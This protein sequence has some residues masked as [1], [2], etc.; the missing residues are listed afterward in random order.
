MSTLRLFCYMTIG[1][2]LLALSPMLV[3]WAG[4][5]LVDGILW[6]HRVGILKAKP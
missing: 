1:Y 2:V 5:R 3:E 4:E 6:L